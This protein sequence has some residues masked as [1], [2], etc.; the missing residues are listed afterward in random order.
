MQ[1]SPFSHRHG[2][3]A[4]VTRLPVTSSIW[5]PTFSKPTMPLPSRARWQ[6]SHSGKSSCASRPVYALYSSQT[7]LISGPFGCGPIA[8]PSGWSSAWQSMPKP[9]T[10]RSR[11]HSPASL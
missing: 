2:N 4:N 8:V 3:A 10:P 6:G 7:P 9:L 1:P 11:S 5:P